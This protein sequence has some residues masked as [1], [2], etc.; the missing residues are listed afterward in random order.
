MR[1]QQI[2][3]ETLNVHDKCI[4]NCINC[5][6]LIF[7]G[8]RSMKLSRFL[9]LAAVTKAQDDTADRRS[10]LKSPLLAKMLYDTG[11]LLLLAINKVANL[12]YGIPN[13]F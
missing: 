10:K 9:L 12:E 8:N 11:Y 7:S 5:I 6:E 4:V 3:S 1:F 13:L 2:C